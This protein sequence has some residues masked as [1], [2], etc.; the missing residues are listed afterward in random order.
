M[1]PFPNPAFA[2]RATGGSSS[3]EDQTSSFSTHEGSTQFLRHHNVVNAAPS[4]RTSGGATSSGRREA[5]KVVI[6]RTPPYAPRSSRFG[7]EPPSVEDDVDVWRYA[8][9]SCIPE[10]MTTTPFPV[11]LSA[12]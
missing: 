10:T 3:L 5:S 2:L 1:M 7:S 4:V 12:T 8:V 9:V 6:Q 11:N